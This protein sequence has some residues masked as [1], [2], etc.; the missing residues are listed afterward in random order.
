MKRFSPLISVIIVAICALF[1]VGWFYGDVLLNP[2]Q[3]VFSKAGDGIKNYYNPCYYMKHDTGVRT[4]AFTYPYGELNLFTDSHFSL[5]YFLNLIDN[6]IIEINHYT[7]GFINWGMM[8]SSVLCAIFLFLIL[9]YFKVPDWYAIIFALIITFLSPQLERLTAHYSLAWSFFIPMIWYFILR[10]IE[11]SRPVIWF[12]ALVVSIL[13]FGFLHPYYLP[14]GMFFILA[15][16]GVYTLQHLRSLKK[17]Y[18]QIIS[19]LCVAIL[20]FILFSLFISIHDGI[21]DRHLAPYGMFVY[22]TKFEGAFMPHGGPLFNVLHKLFVISPTND[23]EGHAYIGIIGIL[24]LFFTSFRLLWNLVKKRISLKR[25][26]INNTLGLSVVAAGLM[27]YL[28][29]GNLFRHFDFLLEYIPRLR[30]FRSLGRFAW[31]LYYVFAVY[32]AYLLYIIYRF[33]SIK[34]WKPVGLV[35]LMGLGGGWALESYLHANYF[36]GR[37]FTQKN[38]NDVFF[39]QQDFFTKALATTAYKPDDFQAIIGFPYMN[40]GTEKLYIYRHGKAPIDMMKCAYDTGL[41]LATFHSPRTS[42]KQGTHL[43]QLISSEFIHKEILKDFN[44]KPLLLIEST[45]NIKP[46]GRALLN[47]AEKIY[48]NEGLKLYKADLSIFQTN[49]NQLID[50]FKE[51]KDNLIKYENYWTTKPTNA[52]TLIRYPVVD[53]PINFRTGGVFQSGKEQS[54]VVFDEQ[55]KFDSIPEWIEVSTWFYMDPNHASFPILRYEEID[56]NEEIVQF[57]EYNAKLNTEVI[58]DFAKGTLSLKP[59]NAKNRIRITIRTENEFTWN[60]I[61]A[62]VLIRPSN[63]DVYYDIEG[64]SRFVFNNYSIYPSQ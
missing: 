37:I 3:Y 39:K 19:L 22:N 28:A 21:S 48:E 8:L 47:K 61:F 23:F 46:D 62:D 35:L 11:W 60:N 4:K 13:F 2:N 64:E 24:A 27:F 58:T 57:K 17:H 38:N 29:T 53:S 26:F 45:G 63:I 5:V 44:D 50:Q 40:N 18:K 6:H 51:E 36:I 1:I 59:K 56:V 34:G 12:S 41:P 14:A 31:L 30:Q 7:V 54:T 42:I 25:V 10:L 52:V 20:P 43:A 15:F 9:Q 55:I 16:V 33:L 49:H 32:S